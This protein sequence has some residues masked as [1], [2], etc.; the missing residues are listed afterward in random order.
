M[1]P[2]LI[3]HLSSEDILVVQS[4]LPDI[5]DDDKRHDN[6]RELDYSGTPKC[7]HFL[8]LSRVS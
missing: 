2:S 7:G 8:D 6:I 3:G 5:D 4:H 1:I